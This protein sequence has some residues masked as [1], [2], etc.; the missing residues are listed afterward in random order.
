MRFSVCIPTLNRAEKLIR[1]LDS[2]QV[3]T[4]KEPFEILVCDNA[5]NQDVCKMILK[6]NETAR[7]QVKYTSQ[8]G[9]I[10]QVRSRLVL[11][12]I[13]DLIVMIDDDESACAEL[14][15]VTTVLIKL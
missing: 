5:C 10:Q 1:A 2:F 14:L 6:Y 11:E 15:Q 7:V 3:Q 9:G 8:L 13:G 12:S 4:Y